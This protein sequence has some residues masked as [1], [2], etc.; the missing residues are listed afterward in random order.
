MKFFEILEIFQTDNN[1]SAEHLSEA[2]LEP[3]QTSKI[4]FLEKIVND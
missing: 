2:Y 3:I 4:E 1:D